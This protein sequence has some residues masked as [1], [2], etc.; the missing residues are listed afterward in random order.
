MSAK[1]SQNKDRPLMEQARRQRGALLNAACLILLNVQ[2][3]PLALL[4]TLLFLIVGVPYVTAFDLL[5]RNRRRT[6]RLFRRTI[7]RYGAVILKCGWPFV[8]VRFVDHAPA[9][10]PPFV[11]VANHLS[12]S[13]PFLMAC[14]PFECIQ[15]LNNWPARIP[16]LGFFSLLAGYLKVREMPIEDYIQAGSKLLAEGTSIIAFPEGTRSRSRQM[17]PFHGSTFRLAQHHGAKIVPLA[18][19][20]NENIPK[21]GSLLL[22]PGLIVVTKL[23]A[24][25]P[26][27][28][29]GMNAYKLKNRIH[30]IIQRNL[31]GL[32]A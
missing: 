13:D 3:W 24:I 29:A 27:E 19:S 21:R 1:D 30:D 20:G 8:R 5:F 2:F 16:V 23:P 32:S 6:L 12:S 18:I 4:V 7:S 15:V 17:G 9:D 22:R 31:D 11:F 26:I 10:P 25:S 14:L 28:Y